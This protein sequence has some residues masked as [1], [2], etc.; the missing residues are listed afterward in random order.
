MTE[1]DLKAFR[2]ALATVRSKFGNDREGAIRLLREEG[3]VTAEGKLTEHY[4]E[5]VEA[6]RRSKERAA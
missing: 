2:R 5:G 6:V 1:D 3:V 4:A